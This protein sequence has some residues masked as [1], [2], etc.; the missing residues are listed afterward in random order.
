[1]SLGLPAGIT[2]ALAA[3]AIAAYM[4]GWVGV[5]LAPWLVTAIGLIVGAAFSRALV[6]GWR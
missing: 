3:S 5:T 1:M 6:C 2:T 4:L